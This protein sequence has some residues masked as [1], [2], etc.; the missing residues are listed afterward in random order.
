MPMTWTEIE[1]RVRELLETPLDAAGVGAWLERRDGLE[2]DVD[3]AYAALNRAKDEDTADEAAKA[4]FLTFVR[5]VLPQVHEADHAL[6]R[7]LA[8]VPDYTPPPDLQVAWLDLQDDIAVFHPDNIP[9]STREQELQQRY[10][11]L[12]GS[13][14]AVLDGET[15]TATQAR[16]KLTEP[17]RDLRERA[18]RALEEGLER[19]RAEMDEVYIELVRLR[20]RMARNAGFDGFLG[21]T[22]RAR[23]RRDYSPDDTLA[24]HEAVARE[25][26]PALQVRARR[27]TDA[28]GIATLR[29]W[30]TRVDPDGDAPLRP[31]STVAELEGGLQRM[32]DALDP[33]LGANFARLR[34]GWMDLEPRPNKVPGLGYQSYF[35]RSRMP[36]IYWSAVG[37]DDDLVTMRHEAGHAFHSLA[38]EARWPLL[39]HGVNRPE[40]AELASQSLE[41][42]TLPYLEREQGGFYTPGDARRSRRAQLER[43]LAL[44]VRASAVDAF[45]HWVYAQDPESLTPDGLDA[46]WVALSERFATGVDWSGLER[47]R[48]KGWQIVHCFQFPLYFI[49]YGIAYLGAMQLWKGALADPAGALTSYKRALALG[50]T[51]PLDQMYA[52][53]GA[54]FA[55]D[56]GTVR[57][58]TA[59]VM[60]Q[61]D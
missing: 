13:V 4:A 31:F 41:L 33:D 43:V 2:R 26:V 59:F 1:P 22:W 60:D 37:T 56:A 29:P 54:R 40:A 17:D 25:V 55:F 9:L 5:E 36:Y 14:R 19:V 38:T 21:M 35:P 58:L 50:G 45:Q 53:A 11:E 3:E 42:L 32:F 57:E 6:D 7:K 10:S 24:L 30:D 23:H 18:Y 39:M 61:L 49:E 44:W 8:G 20:H 28:L 52:T 12:S 27:R 48:A 16:A 34:D 46:A 47:D 51:A 15:I